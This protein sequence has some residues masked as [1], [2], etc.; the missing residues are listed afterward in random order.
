MHV[1]YYIHAL[2]Y[3]YG[4]GVFYSL[5]DSE[6]LNTRNPEPKGT[7]A[8]GSPG[9]RPR[10]TRGDPGAPRTRICGRPGASSRIPGP[11]RPP[12]PLVGPKSTPGR[13]ELQGPGFVDDWGRS[14]TIPDPWRLPEAL[15]R[16][17]SGPG[18]PGAPRTRIC[19]RPGAVVQNSWSLGPR[20]GL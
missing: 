1:R 5:Y 15:G 18:R 7:Q 3:S 8:G 14:S 19:G 6:D 4:V 17:R 20:G 9:Q 13:P 11:W 12:E 10:G 16:P 2:K